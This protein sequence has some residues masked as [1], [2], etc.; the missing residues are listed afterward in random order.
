LKNLRN[1]RI[2]ENYELLKKA[3]TEAEIMQVF[4]GHR[5][6]IFDLSW[7]QSICSECG[8]D[9]IVLLEIGRAQLCPECVKRAFEMMA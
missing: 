2:Y 3:T 7:M 4:K 5:F 6:V 1:D 8:K 9:S